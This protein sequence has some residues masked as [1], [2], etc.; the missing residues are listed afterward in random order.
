[1]RFGGNVV[2]PHVEDAIHPLRMQLRNQRFT[3]N[4]LQDRVSHLIYTLSNTERE[5]ATLLQQI[6]TQQSTCTELK[7][8]ISSLGGRLDEREQTMEGMRLRLSSLTYE[9]SDAE[10]KNA[11]LQQQVDQ[12]KTEQSSNVELEAEVASLMA[13]LE[14]QEQKMEALNSWTSFLEKANESTLLSLQAELFNA[15]RKNATLQQQVDQMKYEQSSKVELATEIASLMTRLEEREQRMDVLNSRMSFV[16]DS[17]GSVI[18]SLQEELCASAE[19]KAALQQQVEQLKSQ[20][21][22]NAELK[23]EV[24]SLV[25]SSEEREQMVEGLRLTISSLEDERSDEAYRLQQQVEQ[26]TTEQ[27]SSQRV[28]ASLQTKVNK[29]AQEIEM[30]KSTISLQQRLS[31]AHASELDGMQRSAQLYLLLTSPKVL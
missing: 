21:L 19:A 29:Q 6:E 17:N 20:Q 31:E 10:R 27:S 2:N 1:M 15:E 25:A 11:T 18:S 12:I 22:F 7:A 8:E 23:T 28:Y 13:R 26:M 5:K 30:M 24:S 16:E 4:T 14:E 9:L 3:V